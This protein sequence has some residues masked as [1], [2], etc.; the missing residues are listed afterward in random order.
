[1]EVGTTDNLGSQVADLDTQKIA[2]GRG[3]A[4]DAPTIRFTSRGQLAAGHLDGEGLE[5]GA[6]HSPTPVPDHAR[7][8]FVDRK[9]ASEL[10]Q[11][12]SELTN[13]DLV[14]V[15]VVDDGEALA[16]IA[17]GS[18][19]FIIAN[20]FLEHCEDPIG[21]IGTHLRK[22]QP[23]GVLFYTVPDK[24]YT[25][26]HRRPVTP[27]EH[28]IADH[29]EGPARSRREHYE[30]WA[31][32]TP[33][34]PEGQ[35]LTEFERWAAGHAGKLE[36]EAASIHMHVWTQAEFLQLIL[37]CRTRFDDAF[38]IEAAVRLGPEFVVVLRK[39]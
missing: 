8:R 37:H 2:P 4:A 9:P 24:R 3:V 5:I 26:D 28:M 23:G 33:D 31:L 11:E 18:Q 34:V 20:H 35:D 21:T 15:D 1:V 10:R 32:L 36:D 19:A 16:T 29:E 38:D 12:Y 22:L 27:L 17:D 7:S 14:E 30:E 25:F 39:R 13:L 6:L